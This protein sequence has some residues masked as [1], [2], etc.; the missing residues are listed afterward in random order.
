[1]ESLLGPQVEGEDARSLERDEPAAPQGRHESTGA[2]HEVKESDGG[3]PRAH[4]QDARDRVHAR[5]EPAIGQDEEGAACDRIAMDARVT[6]ERV[7]DLQ[8][9]CENAEAGEANEAVLGG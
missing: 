6:H 4:E 1:M 5:E 9:V 7:G 8:V 2:R 3:K